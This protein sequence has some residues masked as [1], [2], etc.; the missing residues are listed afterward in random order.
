M[1][2]LFYTR[3]KKKGNKKSFLNPSVLFKFVRCSPT[4]RVFPFSVD[5]TGLFILAGIDR[6]IGKS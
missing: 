2:I 3:E 5:Q 1:V 6:L 4:K